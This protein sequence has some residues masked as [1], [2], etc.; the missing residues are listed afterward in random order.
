MESKK[1]IQRIL[2]K[3]TPAILKSYKQ[4]GSD[5]HNNAQLDKIAITALKREY[6]R[7]KVSGQVKQAEI[8]LKYIQEKPRFAIWHSGIF[9]TAI[10]LRKMFNELIFESEAD[11]INY[12]EFLCLCEPDRKNDFFQ[13]YGINQDEHSSYQF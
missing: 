9:F 13:V 4:H 6:L 10:A 5:K 12:I 7:L 3:E 11:K 1:I 2:D 8:L